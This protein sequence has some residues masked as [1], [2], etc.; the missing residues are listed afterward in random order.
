MDAQTCI[1]YYL[2]KGDELSKYPLVA[3]PTPGLTQFCDLSGSRVRGLY[4]INGMMYAVCD[5]TFYSID[6]NGV[7]TSQ[8]TLRSSADFVPVSIISNGLQLM[9]VEGENKY[10]YTIATAQFHNITD[11]NFLTTD[12][13]TYQDGYGIFTQKDTNKYWI[14]GINNFTSIANLDYGTAITTADNLVAAYSLKQYLYLFKTGSTEVAY[15]SGAAAFPFER[16]NQ[17]FMDQGCAAPHSIAKADN[18]MFWLSQSAQGRGYVLKVDNFTPQV[19]STPPINDAI[20]QYTTISDAI[21]YTYQDRG[22]LFYVLT[23]PSADKTWVYDSSVQAWHQRTSTIIN[24]PGSGT[25]QGRHLSNCYT[26]FNNKHYVG[27]FQSGK[28]YE[29]TTS[30]FTDNTVPILRELTGPHLYAEMKRVMCYRLELDVTKGQGVQ[31]G[32]GSD[33]EIMLQISRDGGYTYGRE[34][35]RSMG[36]AGD[37]T[38]RVYWTQLGSSRDFV[39]RIRVTDPI[40]HAILGGY[41][42]YEVGET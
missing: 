35:T 4:S 30:T 18:S 26:F 9:L 21:G 10:Y 22:H 8:G 14:T 5:N 41:A 34:M 36:A 7:A 19:I 25:R 12:Q 15:N 17:A 37:Y 13:V 40:N 33:P 42:D 38:K 32:Q 23:F 16:V 1:N 31:S 3:Y 2:E 29:M 27:D 11:A 24:S 6:S 20:S 28:I 39:A